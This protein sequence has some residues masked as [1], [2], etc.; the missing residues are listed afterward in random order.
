MMSLLQRLNRCY[1]LSFTALFV[2]AYVCLQLL[3]NNT[4]VQINIRHSHSDTF[5][6][7]WTT[8]EDASWSE[9]KSA[10]VY[11]NSRKQHHILRLPIGL[12]DIEILRIDP[13][14]RKGVKTEISEIS[15]Y[16]LSTGKVT[17][18]SPQAFSRFEPIKHVTEQ[19]SGDKLSFVSSG[20]DPGFIVDFSR[21]MSPPSPLVMLALAGL[22]TLA[23]LAVYSRF[24]WL[25]QELRW[26]PA[27]MLVV[28]CTIVALAMISR[29]NSHPDEHVHLRG[30]H[31]YVANLV[32]PQV[33]SKDA[34]YT[35][36]AYGV[37]RLD[38]R[39]IAYYVGGRY[40]Q[41][42]DFIP[43]ADYLKLRFL[44]I[45]MFFV[46]VLLA[47][48]HVRA[49]YL[50]FPLLLTPQTWYLFSY[51][52]SDAMSL[53]A[54]CLTAYQVFVPES[55]LRR[56]LRGERPPGFVFWVLGLAIIVAMQFWLKLNYMFYP[57]L[58]VMLG[59]SW[60][61]SSR[62][63]PSM[64]FTR[65]LWIALALGVALFLS[66]EVSRHAI[67]DFALGERTLDCREQL[68][69]TKYKPSTPLEQTHYNLML[70]D[71]GVSLYDMLFERNWAERI[72]YTGLGAYG[73]TEYLNQTG[74]YEV[75]SVFILLLLVYVMLTVA[76][77]GGMMGRLSVLSTLAAIF[78]IT[79]AAAYINWTADYQPQGRYLMV[80]IPMLGTLIAMYW[81]KLSV[82]WLT[83]LAVLPF[84]MGLYS[85]ISVALVEIPR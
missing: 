81:Q 60:W 68:A 35:Y 78:G 18:D 11:V 76:L 73:Y 22:L 48:N 2:L 8:A 79:A 66:W 15:L 37:S 49:R 54:V 33:C 55:M 75:V 69:Q 51:Y 16:N 52:N 56:L 17:F 21:A 26:V 23:L 53:F 24:A 74:H 80:Y 25:A 19:K 5:K 29:E 65:P 82:F 83:V 64:S 1:W 41:L 62:R 50:F 43:A 32:P 84:F 44:N 67:N 34:H 61:L 3:A 31:Y 30:A 14:E 45:A 63:I 38:N 40:L 57:I 70:R 58:L 39:E 10:S 6:V 28:A 42:V 36:S 27:G 9:S 46:L 13:G 20:N 47:F 71:K 59:V 77:R 85:F 12:S 4:L 7:Y 72:F